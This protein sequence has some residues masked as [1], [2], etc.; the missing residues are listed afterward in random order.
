MIPSNEPKDGDFIAYIEQLQKQQVERL[1][2]GG[3]PAMEDRPLQPDAQHPEPAS[4]REG[5]RSP[6][7]RS[8]RHT[9]PGLA[10]AVV[11]LFI[12]FAI[13]LHWLTGGSGLLSLLIALALVA[14]GARQLH[15]IRLLQAAEHTHVAA[16]VA[17]MLGQIRK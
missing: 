5:V 7:R 2:A 11:P 9:V 8:S 15:R 16:R 17:Q 12:G 4:G 14:Y 1:H 3:L 10:S 6:E 13:G